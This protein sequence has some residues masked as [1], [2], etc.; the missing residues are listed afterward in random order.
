MPR[1]LQANSTSHRLLSAASAA[2]RELI[3]LA[4]TLEERYSYSPEGK[5]RL[6]DTA[7]FLVD[8]GYLTRQ[9]DDKTKRVYYSLTPAGEAQLDAMPLITKGAAQPRYGGK[10]AQL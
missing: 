9:K 7:E 5:E 3:D 10:A 2:P 8:H 4:A 6:R 1:E